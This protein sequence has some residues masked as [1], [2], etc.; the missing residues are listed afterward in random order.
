MKELD[1]VELIKDREKYKKQ[2]VKKGDQGIILGGDRN[3]YFLVC[4]EGEIYQNAKGIYCTTDKFVAMLPEDL[5]KIE[6]YT[7]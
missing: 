2:G 4:F 1:L 7:K 3:G 5:K 6:R